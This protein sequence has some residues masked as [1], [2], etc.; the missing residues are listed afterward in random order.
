V[1][2]GVSPGTPLAQSSWLTAVVDVA[3]DID[4]VAAYLA[5]RDAEP[6][7]AAKVDVVVLCGSAVLASLDTAARAVRAQQRP[8]LVVTGGI[9]HSTPFLYDAV[10]NTPRYR[11]VETD[12][13]PEAAIL[14]EILRSHHGI[15]A[16]SIT[17]E[18]AATNC[19]ENAAFTITL[20]PRAV[21]SILVIQDP[22]M[23]RRTHASFE[24]C[25]RGSRTQ[26]FSC[27]PFVPR[28][29]DA[30][31]AWPPDRFISLLLGEIRR[32]APTGYGPQGANYI[33][34]VDIPVEVVT[35]H[36]RL[37]RWYPDLA[38]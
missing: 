16:A 33:D 38:R 7:G 9:G 14:A 27:A 19:G 5:R 32:L 22:T 3:H 6:S 4:L 34:D 10:R 29:E 30:P 13:R 2:C 11:D 36:R 25:L 17:V 20:L 24:R 26:V 35:A 8:R 21:R 12:P 1:R 31:E 37:T 15:P 23:Q 28:W 18:E